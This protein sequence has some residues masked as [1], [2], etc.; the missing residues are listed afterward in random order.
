MDHGMEEDT[1]RG[2]NSGD[3]CP[4]C[5]MPFFPDDALSNKVSRKFDMK[6]SFPAMPAVPLTHI[7][8]SA[9]P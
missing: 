6:T 3:T 4:R 2:K 8:L 9:L 5:S 1:L 7:A